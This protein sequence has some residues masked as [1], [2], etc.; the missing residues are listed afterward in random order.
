MGQTT[1]HQQLI[2]LDHEKADL[3][4]KLA[5][6]TRIPR[7]VLLREAVDDL[8]RKHKLLKAERRKP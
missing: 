4:A 1:R 6:R 2:L 8:L 3:L 5:E 7:Q